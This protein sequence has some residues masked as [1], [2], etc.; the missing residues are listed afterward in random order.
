MNTKVGLLVA[1]V[2]AVCGI[3][4]SDPIVSWSS[5][6]P[7]SESMHQ[8]S[9]FRAQPAKVVAVVML[10]DGAEPLQR[11]MAS[12]E[13]NVDYIFFC[14]TGS[15]YHTLNLLTTYAAADPATVKLV[16][17]TWKGRFDV[18]RNDCMRDARKGFPRAEMMLLLNVDDTL[19]VRYRL[20][21]HKVVSMYNLVS[22]SHSGET[23]VWRSPRLV[24]ATVGYRYQCQIHEVI[25]EPADKRHV[26]LFDYI[27]ILGGNH[28][29]ASHLRPNKLERN[30]HMLQKA[31]NDTVADDYGTCATRYQFYLGETLY[32]LQQW[33]KAA[34]AYYTRVL[35]GGN[36]EEVY[37]AAYKRA[38]AYREYYR[39]HYD[40]SPFN[41][42]HL[43]WFAYQV[44]PSRAEA[45]YD[46]AMMYQG[47]KYYHACHAAFEVITGSP[48]IEM[49]R[50]A[51]VYVNPRA[52]N[53][54]ALTE[55]G[56]CAYYIGLKDRAK[57]LWTRALKE[58]PAEPYLTTLNANLK[59]VTAQK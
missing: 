20:W 4:L 9:V 37:Y 53:F 19:I 44:L 42:T 22:M 48:G 10:R 5:Y 25:P 15:N 39:G 31:L 7:S 6:L 8:A 43:F 46:L 32:E 35:Q 59:Y 26:E 28:S 17:H 56:V 3:I 11:L 45:L 55:A 50:D 16:E 57:Q 47:A 41:A 54:A 33:K 23:R 52:Y 2:F 27:Q 38:K 1:A 58:G 49:P 13:G 18:N 36:R 30:L 34:D 14:D 40:A 12:L 29:V 21:R 24:N 51:Q